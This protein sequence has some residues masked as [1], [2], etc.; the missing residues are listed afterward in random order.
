[1]ILI[2][3]IICSSSCG[4]RVAGLCWY[5]V[6]NEF[7]TFVNTGNTVWRYIWRKANINLTITTRWNYAFLAAIPDCTGCN[8]FR[9]LCRWLINAQ[10]VWLRPARLCIRYGW[11]SYGN[12][13]MG[14]FKKS[15]AK[16]TRLK[17]CGREWQISSIILL[18]SRSISFLK[19]K[20]SGVL[21]R[22]KLSDRQPNLSYWAIWFYSCQ[23]MFP[24]TFI[25]GAWNEN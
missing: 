22:Q 8:A 23:V 17:C 1:M 13:S 10:F 15:G 14:V 25:N 12:S 21:P 9:E 24:D 5:F 2:T 19:S 6:R 3:I 18:L 11:W 20:I 4:S 16:V 7:H